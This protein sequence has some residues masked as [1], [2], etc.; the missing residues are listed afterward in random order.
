MTTFF[1]TIDGRANVVRGMD[2]WWH[3]TRAIVGMVRPRLAATAAVALLATLT[4]AWAEQTALVLFETNPEAGE[5]QEG[6]AFLEIDPTSP[7][8]GRILS[9]TA[10]P[11]ETVSHHL[12]YNPDRTKA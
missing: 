9:E 11:P 12:F 6:L 10:F 4:P 3:A 7:N 5:R 1:K 8:Y 2:S